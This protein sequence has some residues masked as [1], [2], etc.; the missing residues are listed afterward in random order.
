MY[1]TATFWLWWRTHACRSVLA[2]GCELE[3]R[4]DRLRKFRSYRIDHNARQV[5]IHPASSRAGSSRSGVCN[6]RQIKFLRALRPVMRWDEW[7]TRCAI[8]TDGSAMRKSEMR[9]NHFF[10]T[11]EYYRGDW[12]IVIVD[13][14]V[15]IVIARGYIAGR[16]WGLSKA[17]YKSTRNRELIVIVIVVVIGIPRARYI[18]DSTMRKR[19][20]S[21]MLVIRK[22]LLEE[23]LFASRWMEDTLG[24]C[25]MTRITSL[26]GSIET[27]GEPLAFLG[28]LLRLRE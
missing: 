25:R 24:G 11:I 28:G 21:L 19:R 8:I 3:I 9:I 26:R 12:A 17:V 20:K 5:Q 6:R 16:G 27:L 13:C 7:T 23:L 10:S 15:R 14:C 4:R 22:N 18:R 2:A 1:N